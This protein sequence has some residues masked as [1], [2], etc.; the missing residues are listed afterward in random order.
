MDEVLESSSHVVKEY[1]RYF[2]FDSFGE[3]NVIF[4]L[5]VQA[6]DR[7]GSFI[8]QT[9]LMQKLHQ[10]LKTEGIV[11]NYPVRTL[12]FP[13]EW[14]PDAIMGLKGADAL[15]RRDGRGPRRRRRRGKLAES[16]APSNDSG[17]EPDD[18]TE[19]GPS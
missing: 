15:S 6:K 12:Q 16:S 4:W 13:K 17:H 7:W 9:E 11:I 2:G 10:R 18:T 14:G 19:T 8:V 3:S 5:F 1:G